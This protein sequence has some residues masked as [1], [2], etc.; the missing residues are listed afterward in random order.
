VPAGSPFAVINPS[1]DELA[2]LDAAS[3]Q[4]SGVLKGDM[5]EV[6]RVAEA[7][8][9]K[10]LATFMLDGT[11]TVWHQTDTGKPVTFSLPAY[12]YVACSPDGQ[13]VAGHGPKE[14]T[15][16]LWDVAAQKEVGSF[17]GHLGGTGAGFFPDSRTLATVTGEGVKLWDL[18]TRRPRHTLAHRVRLYAIAPDG[19]SLATSDAG[20]RVT[21][22]DCATG[23]E[24]ASY[25]GPDN[26][27][28]MF[29]SPDGSK[30]GITVA[31]P[32][33]TWHDGLSSWFGGGRGFEL[34]SFKEETAVLDA[35]TGQ[36]CGRMP[37]FGSNVLFA[38]DKTLATLSKTGDAIQLWEL[39]PGRALQ[40][41][42][43]WACL[44]VALVLTGIW[45]YARAAGQKVKRE[46]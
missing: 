8:S 44:G 27:Q 43:A 10:T 29:F 36:D 13:M 24:R 3:G 38:D 9:R 28:M 6:Y 26:A 35:A 16:R 11:V 20:D 19:Q 32:N 7:H 21:L 39:P 17:D 2:F 31:H 4:K 34:M 22:W 42:G 41:V 30:V 14:N 5:K 23:Q 1:K 15:T 12:A 37:C 40:G 45:W 46:I 33:S 18:A 25:P